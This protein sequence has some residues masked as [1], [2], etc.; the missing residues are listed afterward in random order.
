[1]SMKIITVLEKCLLKWVNTKQ[2]E[3]MISGCDNPA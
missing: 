3:I 2:D 1:V